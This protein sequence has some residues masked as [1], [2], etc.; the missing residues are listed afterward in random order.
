MSCSCPSV[1]PAC[2]QKGTGWST[3]PTGRTQASRGV[4]PWRHSSNGERHD[5][6]TSSHSNWTSKGGHVRAA[7]KP[8]LRLISAP[9]SLP[10][11]PSR[12][13]RILFHHQVITPGTD[14]KSQPGCIADLYRP[15]P[16]APGSLAL[17]SACRI[18]S[19]QIQPTAADSVPPC[20]A[21]PSLRKSKN[22]RA[23]LQW[24][25]YLKDR[26]FLLTIKV[27]SAPHPTG[28]ALA[29]Q[30]MPPTAQPLIEPSD[31]PD[32][33]RIDHQA[34]ELGARLQA[35]RIGEHLGRV[36]CF[37]CACLPHLHRAALR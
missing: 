27:S 13:F 28:R 31:L 16:K 23:N 7:V 37:G 3:T 30:R 33:A 36:G 15:S 18:G 9:C 10:P 1:K 20:S 21:R 34:G 8:C 5:L 19:T 4:R 22:L 35:Y 32:P 14:S 12:P 11:A 24:A 2:W 26:L 6:P 29:D 17:P 25:T